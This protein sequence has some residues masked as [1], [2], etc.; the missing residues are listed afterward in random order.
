MATFWVANYAQMESRLH[1]CGLCEAGNEPKRVAHIPVI[2][3]IQVKFPRSKKRR[4]RKKWAKRQ[5]NYIDRYV[6]M[7]LDTKSKVFQHIYGGQNQSQTR[8]RVEDELGGPVST[9]D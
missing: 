7:V 4:I 2:Q 3:R 9:S 6:Q 5:N 1:R 8:P